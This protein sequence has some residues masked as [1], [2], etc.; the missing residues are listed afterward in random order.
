MPYNSKIQNTELLIFFSSFYDA[1]SVPV[2][3]LYNFDDREKTW[4]NIHALSRI[5]TH[6]LS[7]Q[8]IK[9][10]VSDHAATVTGIID[11]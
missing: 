6:G 2:L 10:Y 11:C 9:A 3:G 4:T 1:F 8:A 7:V 5:Q